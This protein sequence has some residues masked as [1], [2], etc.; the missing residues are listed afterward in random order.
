MRQTTEFRLTGLSIENRC[1][2][3]VDDT[4]RDWFHAQTDLTTDRFKALFQYFK[5][6]PD[7][8]WR[9]TNIAVVE[10]DGL[11]ESGIPK[12]PVV[13]EIKIDV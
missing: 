10:H 1:T 9:K 6:G 13:I 12:N 2:I 8:V 7:D 4:D 5:Y 11:F 3:S